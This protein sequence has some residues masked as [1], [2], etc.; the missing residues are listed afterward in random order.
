MELSNFRPVVLTEKL[1]GKVD[2]GSTH[3]DCGCLLSKSLAISGI[4]PNE[5][6][7]VVHINCIRCDSRKMLCNIIPAIGESYESEK[8]RRYHGLMTP[9]NIK[10]IAIAKGYL[11]YFSDS[12]LLAM[13]DFSQEANAQKIAELGRNDLIAHMV[14]TYGADAIK[15]HVGY[16]VCEFKREFL[17]KYYKKYN[18]DNLPPEAKIRYN[19]EAFL[20]TNYLSKNDV[21]KVVSSNGVQNWLMGETPV[22]Y[23]NYFVDWVTKEKV[24]YSGI[25]TPMKRGLVRRYEK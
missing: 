12:D 25:L 10:S 3:C 21:L 9:D 11:V 23:D 4:P 14:Y 22:R 5:G 8:Y 18:Y 6:E 17:A 24:Q 20:L 7:I 19:Q 16:D 13:I 2:G 1:I 15:E